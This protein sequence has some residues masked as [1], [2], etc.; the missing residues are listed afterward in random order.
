M[1][2]ELSF[3]ADKP[4]ALLVLRLN[5]VAPDG[6]SARVTYRPMN[7]AHRDSHETPTALE[8][9]RQ[10]RVK[11]RLNHAGHRFAQGH[12]IRLALST[13]YWPIVWP[14]PEA[15]KVT[16]H[17]EDCR[18]ILPYRETT[19]G[20]GH[21]APAP[22][23]GVPFP[24]SEVLRKRTSKTERQVLVDGTHTLRTFDDFGANRDP[25]H[26]L[27]SGSSVEQVF[28][29]H[30]EDPLSAR[31]EARWHFTLGRGAWRTRIE[32]ENAM[33]STA[34]DFLL[35]RRVRAYEGE[36]LAFER[37]WREEIPRDCM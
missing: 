36:D 6:S 9:G 28:S 37:A 23:R 25:H 17:L 24:A 29:I 4:Q 5:D 10:Y 31:A 15:A 21:A 27:E 22:P 32:S 11:L 34:Q 8:P 30:P 2:V 26:G 3:S 12:R 14:S 33:T 13:S 35:T 18:V 19:H 20:Q 7:L 1:D 16:L